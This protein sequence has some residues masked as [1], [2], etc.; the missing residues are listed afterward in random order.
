MEAG[1]ELQEG[2]DASAALDGAAVRRKDLRD[3]FEE[4]ALPGAVLPDDPERGA[5]C[6]VQVDVLEGGDHVRLD[7]P[8][9]QH[10][11]LERVVALQDELVGPRDVPQPD[12]PDGQV[13]HSSTAR[14]RCSRRKMA[15][16]D[17]IATALKHTT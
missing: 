3:Q 15:R 6:D 4:R 11:L 14:S 13:A 12:G 1:A 17:T 8:A 5:G 10:G 2:D 9:A 16:P 7:A